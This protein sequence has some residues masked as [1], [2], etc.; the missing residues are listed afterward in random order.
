[1]KPTLI[2]ATLIL[3]A[4]AAQAQNTSANRAACMSDAMSFCSAFVPNQA[5]VEACLRQN[6]AQISPACQ[7]ALGPDPVPQKASQR[8]RRTDG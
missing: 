1:M 4:G 8:R 6:R 2:S 3:V 7:T 5:R